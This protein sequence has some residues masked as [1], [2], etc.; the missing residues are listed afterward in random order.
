MRWVATTLFSTLNFYPN[1]P[2]NQL[3]QEPVQ[4]F[5]HPE[6]QLLQMSSHPPKHV[7]R[8]SIGSSYMPPEHGLQ[9][10]TISLSGDMTNE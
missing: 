8:Q 4:V 9:Y 6:W 7:P 2:A 5:R 10:G 1:K 3:P